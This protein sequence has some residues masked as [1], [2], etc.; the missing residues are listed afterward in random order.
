MVKKVMT[1][2]SGKFVFSQKYSSEELEGLIIEAKILYRTIADLP[3]LPGLASQIEEEVIRKS[4]F[5]TAAIEGNPLAEADVG[6]V[7]SEKVKSEKLQDAEKQIENLK[8]AYDLVNEVLLDAGSETFIADEKLI[9][10]T[11]ELITTGL[12]R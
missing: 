6:K 1:F 9:R 7:L 3:I 11:H 5:G 10:Q 12:A 8:Q 2:K 4:I